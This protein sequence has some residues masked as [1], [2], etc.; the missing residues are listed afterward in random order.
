MRGQTQPSIPPAWW[1]WWYLYRLSSLTR[2]GPIGIGAAG[3][4]GVADVVF[5]VAASLG[6]TTPPEVVLVGNGTVRARVRRGRPRLE[7]PVPMLQCVPAA[8]IGALVARELAYLE[9]PRALLVLRLREAREARDGQQPSAGEWVRRRWRTALAATEPHAVVVERH[10]DVVACQVAGTQVMAAAEARE[11]TVYLE[12]GLWA[13]DLRDDLGPALLDIHA[14]WQA[15]LEQDDVAGNFF[16]DDMLDADERAEFRTLHAHTAAVIDGLRPDD[17][18]LRMPPESDRVPLR[19]FSPEEEARLAQDVYHRPV[20]DG[21]RFALVPDERWH[22]MMERAA[23]WAVASL[24]G[25]RVGPID[26]ARALLA[27]SVPGALAVAEW[28][29]VRHGWRRLH[30]AVAGLLTGP[31]GRRLDLRRLVRD[32][33]ADPAAADHLVGVLRSGSHPAGLHGGGQADRDPGQ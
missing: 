8:G 25:G 3:Q 31:D 2:T 33:S 29:M 1:L 18:A 23:E 24:A 30:P 13:N 15:R 21:R 17:V 26:A 9:L 22:R 5:D 10:A 32:A 6:P 4:P 12:F 20:S 19:A 7:L 14:G 11:A 27:S 28:T 16:D